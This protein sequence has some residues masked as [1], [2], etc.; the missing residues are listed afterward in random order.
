M[1]QYV[2]LTQK[3]IGILKYILLQFK[4]EKL[5]NTDD[6]IEFNNLHEKINEL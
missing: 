1:Q 2:N 5:S 6:F 4:N 3:E